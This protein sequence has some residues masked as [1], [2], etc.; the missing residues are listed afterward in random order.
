MATPFGRGWID[1]QRYVVAAADA[2]GEEYAP[3]GAAV[4]GA[5]RLLLQDR[6][7]LPSMTLADD[8]PTVN[9]E[10]RAWLRS[11]LVDGQEF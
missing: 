9:P 2:L 10:T 1:L 6:P 8:T 5:L 4:R 11:V 3:V 7:E